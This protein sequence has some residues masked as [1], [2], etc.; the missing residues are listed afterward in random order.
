MCLKNELDHKEVVKE[1]KG[2]LYYVPG[3][4]ERKIGACYKKLPS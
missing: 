3:S 1:S 4:L 2:F